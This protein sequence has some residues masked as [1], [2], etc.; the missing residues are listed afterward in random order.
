MLKQLLHKAFLTF[1]II[2][3]LFVFS[4]QVY[5][6][7]E[8]I[9]IVVDG[10]S[11]DNL[12]VI[13]NNIKVKDNDIE[14]INTSDVKKDVVPNAKKEGQKVMFLF[15]KTMLAVAF[16]AVILYIVLVFIK[17]FYGSAFINNESDE[18]E[19][20]DLAAPDN[21]EDALKSFLNRTK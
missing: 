20:F 14:P 16:S 13:Q 6:L 3:G 8:Q 19:A 9:P 7:Q 11:K 4:P 18:Y 17:K 2:C 5:A 10:A 12:N 21:K 15:I 1:C